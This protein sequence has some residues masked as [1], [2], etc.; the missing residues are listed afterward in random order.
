MSRSDRFGRPADDMP[1]AISSMVRVVKLGYRA[2]P[3]G[4]LA[5][6]ALTVLQALPDVLV[7]VWL[8]LVT[9]GVIE[10]DRTKLFVGACGLA[11]SATAIWYL[12]VVL[13]RVDRRLRDRLSITFQA[14]VAHLQASVST[15]EH[16][17]RPDHLDRLSVLRNQIFALDHLFS[18]L[19]STVG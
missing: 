12:S 14:H 13:S 16:Q 7:A 3:R 4:L 5:A 11:L 8:L 2:E 9:N 10:H 15:I 6:L 19:F 1:P 17:E 18:S